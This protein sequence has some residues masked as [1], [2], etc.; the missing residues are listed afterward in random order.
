M[1]AKCTLSLKNRDKVQ[2][3]AL[4][5]GDRAINLCEMEFSIGP[6]IFKK[7]YAIDVRKRMQLFKEKE[8]VSY[9]LISTFVTTFGVADGVNREVVDSEVTAEDLFS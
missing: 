1:E 2:K 4:S 3:G 7:S 5:R 6:Y 9:G 8:K